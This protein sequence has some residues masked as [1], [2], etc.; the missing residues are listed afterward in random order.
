MTSKII[1]EDV[2]SIIKSQDANTISRP[3][4]GGGYTTFSNFRKI[5]KFMHHKLNIPWPFKSSIQFNKIMQ[6]YS[7]KDSTF[8]MD[9]G[10]SKPKILITYPRAFSDEAL[11]F[12]KETNPDKRSSMKGVTHE[13]FEAL[14]STSDIPIELFQNQGMFIGRDQPWVNVLDLE[15]FGVNINIIPLILLQFQVLERL[16]LL[17]DFVKQQIS[18]NSH[19]DS[20]V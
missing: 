7:L 17:L 16:N 10:T 19:T 8:F 15:I 14:L 12:Y 4:F 1:F 13:K 6:D 9:L 11:A 20:I 2:L 3:A 5:I 18:Q